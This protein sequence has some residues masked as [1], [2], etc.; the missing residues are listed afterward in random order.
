MRKSELEVLHR[1]QLAQV[2]LHL[3]KAGWEGRK[4]NLLLESGWWVPYEAVFDYYAHS[5]FL[6]VLYN[7]EEEAIELLI[8]DQI[9]RI[10]FIFFPGVW[11]EQILTT[12]VAYQQQLS[13]DCYKEFIRVIL[14]LIPD[15]VYVY[16]NEQRLR[17]MPEA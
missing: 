2:S 5:S 6:I 4:T 11:F 17:L 12:I 1:W 14:L 16:Q 3:E 8:E 10:N 7:A 15:G 9:G 13:C